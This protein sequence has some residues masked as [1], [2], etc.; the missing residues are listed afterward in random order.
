MP[1]ATLFQELMKGGDAWRVMRRALVIAGAGPLL[2]VGASVG[3]LKLH[4][5]ELIFRAAYSHLQPYGALPPDS[6]RLTI[7]APGG[8]RLA[9]IALHAERARDRGY[10][11][12]HLHGNADSAF[13]I[14]QL[15]HCEQL[16]AIGFSVLCLD[17][18]GFGLSPGIPTE[19]HLNADAEAAYETL[20]GR[21]VPPGRIIIWGHSLG[22]APAVQL[23][24]R[25]PQAAALVL[26]GAFTS[27]ADVAA[28]RYPY[29]PVR[30]I[31]G[32]QMDSLERIRSVHIPVVIA[33]SVADA[34][35]PFRLG[36][37]LYRA[38]NE[39]KR[40][41]ALGASAPP[42][43][44]GGHVDALYDHLERLTPTLAALLAPPSSAQ[45]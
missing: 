12:L 2:V 15:R 28:E 43:P 8:A 41:L 6:K 34:V 14:G 18:E 35:I 26:F 29:L 10:W 17:Y 36:V 13:S 44:L 40:F 24:A 27:I 20:V 7:A 30:G 39:P 25:H 19:A 23:A 45:P 16:R 11:I 3:W 9:A 21:G 37:L 22:S 5:Q 4:E 31:V 38:A 1:A 32:M 33:H 42:E